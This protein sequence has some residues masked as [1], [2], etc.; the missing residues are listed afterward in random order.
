VIAA[1]ALLALL[2]VLLVLAVAIR[3]NSAGPALYRQERIGFGGRPFQMWKL[4]TMHTDADDRRADLSEALGWPPLFKM[5]DDPRVT[6]VGRFLRRWSLDELPQLWNVVTG[7]MSLVGPRP[8]MPDEVGAFREGFA[9]RFAVKPGITGLWQ[10]SGRSA[11]SWEESVR[12]D[13][14]YVDDRSLGLDVR[15]LFRTVPAVLRRDG[16]Y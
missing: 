14:A 2:P 15:I 6:G 13:L 16:A 8:G 11:L 3:L 7:D 5:V 1:L 10:V 4:R 12:L 9:R